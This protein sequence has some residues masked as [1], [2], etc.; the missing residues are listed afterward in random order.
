[1]KQLVFILVF[2]F[3]LTEGVSSSN[4]ETGKVHLSVINN[5]PIIT[6]V[7]ILPAAYEGTVLN[8][9]VDFEDELENINLNYKWYRNDSLIYDQGSAL[10]PSYFDEGDVVTCEVIPYDFVQYGEAKT[11]SMEIKPKPF[12]SLITGAVVGVGEQVGPFNTFII[13]VLITLIILSVSYFF[14]K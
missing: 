3:F 9:E 11:I 1:M 5:P 10:P 4:V 13:L 8:C 14:R 12:L 6:N 7:A 2:L